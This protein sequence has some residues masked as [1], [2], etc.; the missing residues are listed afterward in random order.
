MSEEVLSEAEATAVEVYRD[1]P[2][3]YQDLPA[4]EKVMFQLWLRGGGSLVLFEHLFGGLFAE[5]A[6]DRLEIAVPHG[7]NQFTFLRV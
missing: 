7:C 6:V 2:A 5:Q 3:Y 1:L 4:R